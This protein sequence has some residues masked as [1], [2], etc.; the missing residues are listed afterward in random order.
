M[1]HLAAIAGPCE[2]R[3]GSPNQPQCDAKLTLSFLAFGQYLQGR[4]LEIGNSTEIR[5][6]DLGLRFFNLEFYLLRDMLSIGEENPS[7]QSQQQ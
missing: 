6:N 1:L 2:A 5:G 3:R 7:F 4:I